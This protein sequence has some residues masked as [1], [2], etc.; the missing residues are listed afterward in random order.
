MRQAYEILGL[1]PG[2]T[3]FEAA[4]GAYRA[5]I[6]QYHPDKVA[7]LGQELR[8]LAARKAVEINLAWEYIQKHC[9]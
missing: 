4:K 5:C 1:P 2:K 9:K 3:T 6:A 8:D 7:H